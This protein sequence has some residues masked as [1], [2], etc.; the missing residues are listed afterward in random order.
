MFKPTWKTLFRPQSW[1]DAKKGP[2]LARLKSRTGNDTK[3]A[4]LAPDNDAIA[5]NI[6]PR[7]TEYG[8]LLRSLL[9]AIT[10]LGHRPAPYSE[11]PLYAIGDIHGRLDL[12]LPLIER[13]LD[14][15]GGTSP[16]LVFLGDYIDR[17]P[18]SRGVLDC[19]SGLSSRSELKSVFL[20][21]NHELML[22]GFLK[23]PQEGRRWLRYGGHE[24][25]LSYGVRPPEDLD[26]DNALK[27]TGA[28]LFGALGP[29][30]RFLEKL[31]PMYLS[32]NLLFTHAGADPLLAPEEQNVETL[33]WGVPTFET[34]ARDD[35][36]WVVHGHTI[37]TEPV[38]RNGRISVDTGAWTTGRLTALKANGEALSFLAQTVPAKPRFPS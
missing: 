34:D 5:G 22:L 38:I 2:L 16:D 30:R 36:L 24:T 15:A 10:L 37:V 20:T 33:A 27:Q 17:G 11:N 7:K 13:I 8:T 18:D 26:D 19:L 3:L 23:D 4:F 12:L 9:K 6:A 32:G 1:E 14:D 31:R 25:L 29:H 21:G 28:A 35:G